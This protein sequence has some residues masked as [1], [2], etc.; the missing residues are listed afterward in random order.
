MTTIDDRPVLAA[1]SEP[2]GPKSRCGVVEVR[3]LQADVCDSVAYEWC[4][5]ASVHLDRIETGVV[6]LPGDRRSV[7]TIA[8]AL[9]DEPSA[10]RVP[11]QFVQRDR[12]EVGVLRSAAGGLV[13]RGPGQCR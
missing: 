10:E 8:G 2:A 4:V 3:R 7:G 11:A 9:G 5:F 1:I 12:A 13:D 6:G